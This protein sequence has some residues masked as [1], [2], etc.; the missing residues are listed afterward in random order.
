MSNFSQF[1]LMA[2]GDRSLRLNL[3]QIQTQTSF[4]HR[5]TEARRTI[6]TVPSFWT[7]GAPQHDTLCPKWTAVRCLGQSWTRTRVVNSIKWVACDEAGRIHGSICR[8]KRRDDG[9]APMPCII[10]L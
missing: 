4:P 8:H 1:A 5:S 10:N 3:Q 7:S 6:Y 9:T 2:F